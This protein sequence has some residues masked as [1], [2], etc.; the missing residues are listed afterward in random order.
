MKFSSVL[1]LL[2]TFLLRACTQPVPA[3]TGEEENGLSRGDRTYAP[4]NIRVLLDRQ[5]KAAFSYFFDGADP[6]TGMALE[7]NGREYTL[8]TGGSGFGVMALVAGMERG[9]IT[10]EQ[11]VDR[12]RRIV[13]F[14]S[15]ADRYRGAW[16][17]WYNPDGSY[18]PFGNQEATGDLV[19]TSF[20]IQ[21]LLV[22]YEYLNAEAPDEQKIREAID[23]LCD[24][25]EWSSYTGDDDALYWLWYSREDRHSLKIQ[26]WN[27][28]LC[29][30]LL[31]LGARK[32]SITPETYR[33]GWNVPVFP[34]RTVNGYPF[35]LGREEKGGPLFFSQYSFLG[36]D[37]RHMAD[38][39][40]WYWRQN[41]SHAMLN[42][43]YCLYE[44][45][46][47]YA[48]G[49]GL[50]G[51]TACYGAG[52][53]PNYSAR[54]PYGDDGV[55]APTAALSSFP[56]TPF[57]SAQVLVSLDALGSLCAGE[58]GF[59]DAYR[60]SER[61]AEKRHL[62]IDQGPVVVMMEN[63]RS[64]LI[65]KLFMK[66]ERVQHALER[67]GIGEPELGEGF[68]YVAADSRTGLVDLMAHPDR[69]VFE[70]D[71]YS[72]AAGEARF[73]WLNG[74]GSKVR[75]QSMR[76]VSGVSRLSF[77][78]ARLVRGE[79]Y[80]LVLTLPSGTQCRLNIH[81]H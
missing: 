54:S 26:G 31:A 20:M 14:L 75:E 29:T 1:A 57:Y 52:S 34:G 25:L 58:F 78:D 40:A 39:N 73:E 80:M 24:A 30:Y 8:T 62:A 51:L 47:E 70:L 32:H 28:A 16:S 71:F 79:A 41:L 46:Q 4:E 50:W 10:R 13:D 11:G 65:W 36:F 5:Q 21:G 15:L 38:A 23:S 56:Y 63:Y 55:L 17:H 42:R 81:I 22:A 68:P 66:N 2:M 9:W 74:G 33:N 35:P 19:E 7:G 53:R 37:P 76:V 64:G 59:A 27:E 77:D 12:I 48:Y 45:P 60:P 3:G 6:K 44:A 67:A 61:V 72:S 43:H 69:G 49:P 18:V